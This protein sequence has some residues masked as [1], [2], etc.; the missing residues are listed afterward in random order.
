MKLSWGKAIGGFVLA[1]LLS[2]PAFGANS[3]LPGTLNFV[4]GQASIQNQ[5]LSPKSVGSADLEAGQTIST[6]N[7]RAEILLTPGVFLRLDHNSAVKMI[8]PDLTNTK[9]QLEK[10]RAEVEVAQIY[11]QNDLQVQ[12][13]D[14]TT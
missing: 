6:G 4:E 3:A 11:K 5:P 14:A 9:V 12:Q 8:S 10:G 1:A 13:G 7:G 2:A